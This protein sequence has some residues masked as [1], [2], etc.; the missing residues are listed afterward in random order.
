MNNEIVDKQKNN[1]SITKLILLVAILLSGFH[2]Y[3]A[4]FGT[5]PGY[6]QSSIHWT[7]VG[8]LI[9]L[10]KPSKHKIGKVF[11]LLVIIFLIYATYHQIKLQENM[12]SQAGIFSKTD[13]W[14]SIISIVV[15]LEVSRRLIGNILPILSIVFL[16]YALLGNNLVGIFKSTKLSINRIAPY[17]FTSGDGLFVQTLLVSAQFIFLFVLFGSVLNLTGAGEFFVDLAFSITARAKGGPA[18]AAIYSSM[19]MGTINGSGAANVVTTGTFIIPLMNKVGFKPALS[20]AV[21]A[22]ASSG[23]QIM[24]PVMGAVAF[25]M[26]ELTGIEYTSIA[27]AALVPAL[28]YFSHFLL[29]YI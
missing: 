22:V 15:A 29:L 14:I 17:L 7:L 16:G 1:D 20:G 8:T 25:L 27:K 9:V 23:G 21:E 28:L 26:S 10:T 24:P 6:A 5:L 11:D 2:I 18:Q 3:T 4:S 13:I 19:L 12:I